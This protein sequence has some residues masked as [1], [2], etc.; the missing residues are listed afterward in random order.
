MV[1]ESKRI[2]INSREVEGGKVF[3]GAIGMSSSVNR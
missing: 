3:P 1:W 2:P